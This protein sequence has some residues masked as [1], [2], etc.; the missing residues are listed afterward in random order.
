MNHYQEL[1]D[2]LRAI[3]RRYDEL[4][5]GDAAA[6]RRCKTAAE[7]ALEPAFWRIVPPLAQQPWNFTHVVLLFPLAK[8]I[9]PMRRAFSFGRFLRLRLQKPK[10]A[11]DRRSLRFHRL[12]ASSDRDELD[13]R[14]RGVLRLACADDASVDWG[15]LG[16]DVL[17]FFAESDIVRR[18]WAQDFYAPLPVAFEK[19]RDAVSIQP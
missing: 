16:T 18:R 3:R 1:V 9:N 2:E 7:I 8:Q 14:L 17:W 4:R 13:H 19:G 5:R 6:I 15:V 12:L 10:D 11:D